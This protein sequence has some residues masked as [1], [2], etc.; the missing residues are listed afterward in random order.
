MDSKK[1]LAVFTVLIGKY[2][3]ENAFN[4]IYKEKNVDYY[5]VTNEKKLIVDGY[6]MIY[7]DLN[8]YNKKIT[9]RYYKLL[10]PEF[11]RNKYY[12]SI[13]YDGNV[14]V[15]SKLSNLLKHVKNCN[16]A[17]SSYVIPFNVYYQFINRKNVKQIHIDKYNEYISNG[18]KDNKLN[19]AGKF[20]VR[21]HSEKLFKFQKEWFNETKLLGRDEFS[22]L[23][24][25]WKHKIKYKVINGLEIAK[26]FTIFFHRSEAVQEDNNYDGFNSILGPKFFSTVKKILLSNR[27]VD[28]ILCKFYDT[29]FYIFSILFS[30]F[31]EYL[32]IY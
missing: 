4:E 17:I 32:K 28:Y 16:I 29:L 25:K 9:Q 11:I 12:Y 27:Y 20:L 22:F 10:I 23:Y 2:D 15:D 19:P 18:W 31:Y 7:I 6:K 24:L 5:F 8:K 3:N 1:K 26:Y 21:K 13:Y 30:I 14:R